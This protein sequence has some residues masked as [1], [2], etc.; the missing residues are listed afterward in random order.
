MGVD[1]LLE[2]VVPLDGVGGL[3]VGWLVEEEVD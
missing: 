3:G 1:V 2:L